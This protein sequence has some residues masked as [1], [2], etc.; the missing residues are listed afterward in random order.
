LATG[1]ADEEQ[2]LKYLD[3]AIKTFAKYTENVGANIVQVLQAKLESSTAC[4][5]KRIECA[6]LVLDCLLSSFQGSSSAELTK[7]YT[8]FV[9]SVL[10]PLVNELKHDEASNEEVIRTLASKKALVDTAGKLE[11]INA[12]PI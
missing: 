5:Q 2:S 3:I 1:I 6:N 9:D 10:N 4:L 8:T 11:K 7:L 12:L